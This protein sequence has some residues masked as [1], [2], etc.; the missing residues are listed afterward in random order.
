MPEG[1][2][3]LI[4]TSESEFICQKQNGGPVI[5]LIKAFTIWFL[6][7]GLNL[8]FFGSFELDLKC[9]NIMTTRLT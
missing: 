2:Q 7:L 4:G 3:Y 6:R 9:L 1:E 8:L 5:G